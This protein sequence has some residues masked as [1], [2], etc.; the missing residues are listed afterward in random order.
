MQ[1]VASS[2][3]F[4]KDSM[5]DFCRIGS[6]GEL[7]G[8]VIVPIG[9]RDNSVVVENFASIPSSLITGNNRKRKERIR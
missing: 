3:S 4:I 9:L 7:N 2:L 6:E 5:G 1:A 8:Q